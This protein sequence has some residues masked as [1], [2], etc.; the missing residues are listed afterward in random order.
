MQKTLP[1]YRVSAQGCT[2]LEEVE[3]K[4]YTSDAESMLKEAE[5]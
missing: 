3:R 4:M 1:V 5:H 2:I